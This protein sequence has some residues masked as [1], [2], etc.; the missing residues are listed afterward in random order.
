MASEAAER[1]AGG[2]FALAKENGTIAEKKK[3][4]EELSEA[5]DQSDDLLM[6]LRAVKVTPE[7]KKKAIDEMFQ[8]VLDHDFRS[9]LKL[10]VDKDRTYYLK[11]ILNCFEDECNEALGLQKAEVISARPLAE[12]DL[13]R[14]QDVLEKKT[15]RK[16]LLKKTINPSLIA[17]MKVKVGNEVIDVS[18]K[19]RIENM[20][21]A[22]LKGGRG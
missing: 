9:F 10:L 17:G 8:D 21:E 20:K 7:E 22:I 1:Y 11:E 19:S 13:K 6:F 2:L 18:M 4:A 16:I 3:Q 15:G 12:E 14:I 5:L